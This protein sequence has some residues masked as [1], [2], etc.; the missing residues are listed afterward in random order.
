MHNKA[1]V[2]KV[3]VDNSPDTAAE[4]GIRSIPT[5]VFFKDGKVAEKIVGMTDKERITEV[6]DSLY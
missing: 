1:K 2:C 3:D 4:Y 6:L 5:L